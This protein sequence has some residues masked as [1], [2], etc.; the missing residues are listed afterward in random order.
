MEL[1]EILTNTELA[2]GRSVLRV[3]FEIRQNFKDTFST[4]K[5]HEDAKLWSVD[6]SEREKLGQWAQLVRAV[7]SASADNTRRHLTAQQIERTEKAAAAVLAELDAKRGEQAE[8][9]ELKTK[10]AKSLELLQQRSDELAAVE[11][12]LAFERQE[13]DR[14]QADIDA[15]LGAVIDLPALRKAVDVLTVLEASTN[16]RDREEWTVAQLQI[17]IARNTLAEAGIRLEALDFLAESRE[18]I[19]KMP[20][21]AWYALARSRA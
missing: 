13:R 21:G 14:H 18:L 3:P 8:L 11:A 19:R 2:P 16:R 12:G 6:E 20:P 5:W 7:A 17:V 1:L 9:P 4:W 15:A 10:L